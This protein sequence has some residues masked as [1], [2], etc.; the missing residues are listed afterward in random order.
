MQQVLKMSPSYSFNSNDV[1]NFLFFSILILIVY[2]VMEKFIPTIKG[3]AW[4]IMLISSSTLSI[5][6]LYYVVYAEI[7]QKWNSQFIYN[8]DYFSR[9]I[10][11]FFLASNVM[12]LVIGIFQYP[13]FLDPF[14][15][16]AHHIFYISFITILLSH[17]YSQGFI[18][19]FFMEVP[20]VILSIGT[21]WKH[22]R[23]DI[24]FGVT[25]LLTRII[26]NIIL[27][28]KLAVIGYEGW[29]WK[30]CSL[31]LCLHLYWFSKWVKQYGKKLSGRK[32]SQ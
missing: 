15:T 22:L 31:V 13:K 12:D 14:S 27:I 25:F 32:D 20:T 18:L 28:Y 26:Y 17:H 19:C 4:I 5:F 24:L 29:I 9:C 23:S 30:I 1:Y 2:S 3:K 16:I 6:G 10:L 11:L 8:E 7:Y 21:V